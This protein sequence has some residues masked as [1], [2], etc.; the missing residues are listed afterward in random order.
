MRSKEINLGIAV[1]KI[2]YMTLQEVCRDLDINKGGHYDAGGMA[3]NIWCSDED[4]PSIWDIP[5]NRG[6]LNYPREFVGTLRVEWLSDKMGT[7][8]L[9][10]QPMEISRAKRRDLTD[11]ELEVC[12]EWLKSKTEAIIKLADD[13]YMERTRV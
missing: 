10:A 5:I 12:L 6:A 3:I 1:T 9:E 8:S 7:L 4:K 2:Y 11:N 13:L